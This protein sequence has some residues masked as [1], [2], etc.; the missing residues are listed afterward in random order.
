M[1]TALSKSVHQD[2]S[3]L[4]TS[5]KV[6]FPSNKVLRK[7]VQRFTLHNLAQPK[8]LHK[9]TFIIV[10]LPLPAFADILA[11]T[12]P[13]KWVVG[14]ITDV[15]DNNIVHIEIITDKVHQLVVYLKK[16]AGWS[17]LPFLMTPDYYNWIDRLLRGQED[18][19]ADPVR[20]VED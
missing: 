13:H 6:K 3:V 1:A 5:D 16:N 8:I 14:K 20:H 19:M 10:K 12:E 4:A 7:H 2:L 17:E 18:V 9:E 11:S 15:F